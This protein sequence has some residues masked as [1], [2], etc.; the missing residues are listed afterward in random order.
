MILRL[1][2]VY[3]ADNGETIRFDVD[4]LIARHSGAELF[5]FVDSFAP[6]HPIRDI[7]R[8]A[9]SF[10][11]RSTTKKLACEFVEAINKIEVK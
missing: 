5:L 3:D 9:E 10:L 4:V 2:A 6:N 7:Q 1:N 11:E 8:K